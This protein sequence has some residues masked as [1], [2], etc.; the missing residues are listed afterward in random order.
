M[1]TL[2]RT[3]SIMPGKA[4]EAVAFAHKAKAYVKEK[5]SLDMGL[6][7]PIGGN[8]YRIAFVSMAPSL[9]E[10][11]ALMGKLAMDA[12]YQAMIAANAANVIPGSVHDDIWRT[13]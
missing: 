1:I 10:F 5:Y 8:P 2:V 12:D 3:F 9:A 6:N 7:M 13:I 4:G 11:E